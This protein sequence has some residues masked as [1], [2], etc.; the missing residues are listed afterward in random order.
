MSR[1]SGVGPEMVVAQSGSVR[2]WASDAWTHCL[3]S[4]IMRAERSWVGTMDVGG[5]LRSLGLEQYKAAFRENAIDEGLLA[6]NSQF[7]CAFY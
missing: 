5:W 3:A 1:N 2:S 6:R 7:R 4:T